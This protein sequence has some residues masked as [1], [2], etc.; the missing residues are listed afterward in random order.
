MRSAAFR[1]RTMERT[2]SA[3]FFARF[4][5][6]MRLAILEILWVPARL[7]DPHLPADDPRTAILALDSL[8]LLGS[9]RMHLRCP[10]RTTELH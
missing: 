9:H 10:Q 5:E 8:Y 6:K 7:P 2:V 1:A 3:P 4:A